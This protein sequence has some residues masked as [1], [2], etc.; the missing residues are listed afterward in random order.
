MR[1]QLAAAYADAGSQAVPRPAAVRDVVISISFFLAFLLLIMFAFG[2][3]FHI[4]FRQDQQYEVSSRLTPAEVCQL[5]GGGSAVS[6][7][8]SLP[9]HTAGVTPG[10]HA[11]SC[12]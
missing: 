8:P 11:L 9:R 3:A 5:R 4:L 1:N 2:A 6:R 7:D 10:W 12:L